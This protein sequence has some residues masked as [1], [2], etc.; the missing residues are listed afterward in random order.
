MIYIFLAAFCSL[1]IIIIFKQFDK[2]NVDHNQAIIVNYNVCVLTGC[3]VLGEMPLKA[4]MMYEP[5]AWWM[6]FLGFLF[7]GGFNIASRTIRYFG[8][9]ISAVAQRMSMGISVSFSI[10]YYNEDY[11]LYKIIGILMALLAVVFINIP[12][13]KTVENSQKKFNWLLAFPIGIC[14]ISAVIEIVLQYLNNVHQLL[15]DV[16]AIAMFGSGGLVGIFVLLIQMLFFKAKI[17][18]R[19]IA[20]GIVL[21]IP[22][23]FSLY[24]VLMAFETMEGSTVYALNNILIVLSAALV[25]VVAF[26]EKL[27]P[28]NILGIAFAVFSIFLITL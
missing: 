1:L 19:N 8:V 6:L 3:L 24:F 22:N 28:V 26:Q 21:G 17:T 4:S 10:W 23:Y 27:S 25:G 5:W 7:I 18:W 14:F 2:Y 11:T 16:Q 13:E 20:G 12:T 15:P 9:A